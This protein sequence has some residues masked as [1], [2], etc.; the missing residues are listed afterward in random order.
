MGELYLTRNFYRRNMTDKREA[1]ELYINSEA[2]RIKRQGVL[3]N[4]YYGRPH[5]CFVC[6][7]P[8]SLHV[9]HLTYERLG[10]ENDDDLIILCSI[11]HQEVHLGK[12]GVHTNGN[13][14]TKPFQLKMNKIR[15][16]KNKVK[17]IKVKK[18]K[19]VKLP[20]VRKEIVPKV[21]EP[22]VREKVYSR[23][24]R[25]SGLPL[26]LHG[27][28]FAY[29]SRIESL[30]VDGFLEFYLKKKEPDVVLIEMFNKY[31][32]KAIKLVEVIYMEGI[33]AIKEEQTI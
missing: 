1:Y 31:K 11:C 16:L 7:S 15:P 25:R 5:R 21:K 23:I 30:G 29:R 12:K 27:S 32:D 33:P 20:K 3:I 10:N 14:L 13:I 26:T 17:K 18:P 2:W 22:F 6:S 8:V 24:A 4:P 28:I 19:K 9:H